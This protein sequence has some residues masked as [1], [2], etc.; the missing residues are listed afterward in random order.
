MTV[1]PAAGGNGMGVK[2][3]VCL[4]A[5]NEAANIWRLHKSL[6]EFLKRGGE[7]VL[8]DTGSTDGTPAVAKGLGFKV[9]EAGERF[10]FEIPEALADSINRQFIVEGE[11]KVVSP[12][13]KLFDYAAARNHSARMASN[14]VVSMPDCDEQYTNLNI[15]AIEAAIAAG[16][17][18]M[19]FHFIFSHYPNGKPAVQFRQCK[20]YD[21][22]K[23]HWQGIVHEVLVGAANRTYLPP[24]VLLL[25]HFQAPQTHRSRYMAGLAM[26]CYLSQDNDR[27]SHYFGR[28]L[29][30]NGRNMSAIRELTRHVNMKRWAQERGQSLIF[31]GDA[32]MAMRNKNLAAFSTDGRR[33]EG[34]GAVDEELLSRALD[35]W[36]RAILVDGTRREPWLRLADY[37]EKT[38]DHQ[39]AACYAMASLEIP[40]NDCYCNI[41]AHYTF[42]PHE[43]LYCALWWL[44]VQTGDPSYR[45][46]SKE[47]WQKAFNYFP[48]NPKF[49]SDR[50]FYESAPIEY[51][52]PGI[53]GWMTPGEL[54]WLNRTAKTVGSVL[55]IGSWKGRSSHAL[56]SGCKGKVTCVDTFGGSEDPRDQTNAMAKQTDVKAEFLRNVG[57]F[58]NLEVLQMTSEEAAKK[59]DAE[60]RKFDM[61]FIDA[62]HTYDEVR[63]DIGLWRDKATVILSG[64]DYS[65]VWPDV[66]RAVDDSI[67]GTKQHETIWHVSV[68]PDLPMPVIRGK[69]PE[70]LREWQDKIEQDIPFSFVKCGDGELAC[71]NGDA[72]ANCDGQPYSPELGNALKKAFA[73]LMAHGSYI[74]TWGDR[75]AADKTLLLHRTDTIDLNAIKSFYGAIRNSNHRKVFVGPARLAGAARLLKAEHLVIPDRDAFASRGEIWGKLSGMLEDYGIY[76]FCAGLAA[77]PLIA[78]AMETNSDTRHPAFVT[79]I[80]AG[81]SFDPIFFAQ[82]RTFQVPQAELTKLYADFLETAIPKR[83]FTIWLSGEPYPPVVEKCIASQ[84]VPGYKHHV[85]TMFDCP[86]GI[87]YVEEALAAKRWVN[88]GDYLRLYELEKHGGI[89]CD[90]DV[91]VL[92]GKTFDDLLHHTFFACVE[93]NGWI[94]FATMGSVPGHPVLKEQMVEMEEK[95]SGN[96]PEPFKDSIATFTPRLYHMRDTDPGIGIYPLNYFSPYDHQTGTI[97]VTSDTRVFHH[98]MKSWVDEHCPS[99]ILPRVAILIPTLG[100]EQGLKRCLESIDRLYYPKHLLTV[101]VDDHEG[102][103]PKKVNQ[104]YRENMGFDA[105]V[106]AANDMEFDPYSL[107]R[108]AVAS[109]GHGLVA[110]N[111]GPLYA[112]NGNIC[113]HFLITGVLVHQLGDEI[114]S[115]KFHH[116]GC[117]N[118]LW[119]KADRLGQAFR[120]EDAKVVHHHFSKGETMDWVYRLGWSHMAVD[121]A[122]LKEELERLKEEPP[123]HDPPTLS[124]EA[125]CEV[126]IEYGKTYG[127]TVL[128]ETGTYMGYTLEHTKDHFYRAYSMELSS[129]LYQKAMEKFKDDPKVHLLFGDSGEL[130]GELLPWCPATTEKTLFWLD[131]HYSFPGTARGKLDTPIMQELEAIIA[132][133]SYSVVLIDD[134]RCFDGTHSYPKLDDLKKYLAERAPWWDFELKDDIVRLCEKQPC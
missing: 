86:R 70:S 128:V 62:G 14:D 130:L 4:I 79:C 58:K 66:R 47:H 20:M 69:Y 89:Y 122:V 32:Y 111:G 132:H 104:M 24:D 124:A 23:M 71:M 120:C 52:D 41:G 28:E 73:S 81:S 30:W 67:P 45:K 13:E 1:L 56:L 57:H 43:R 37:F 64:H 102:T 39:K 12:G 3:S 22:R 53:D 113:E 126:I 29:L 103:V 97:D 8:I 61:I 125:K 83:I 93:K 60:G 92:P 42:E 51:I 59:C 72:G 114:F 119:A 38:K 110:F 82:T 46:R 108:A 76:V 50:Q 121:R 31:I 133:C 74:A 100:R 34:T 5:K 98:F 94:N 78:R 65:D 101:V 90:A 96:N 49:I 33:W 2:F 19:E 91:E 99:E 54:D 80:D 134:A 9:F 68:I 109:K 11:E 6:T 27:N 36:H 55:E 88:A 85:V 16:Y 123:K 131:A 17:E 112:D 127:A 7:V 84:T 25:E 105:F 40:P 44:G 77:K 26:D 95:S 18:Q 75:E 21:R 35:A 117:D 48:T 10:L 106:Y 63:K 87:P 129:E 116:V 118:L 115:E 107:Y 15:D